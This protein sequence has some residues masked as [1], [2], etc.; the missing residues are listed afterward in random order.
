MNAY[1]GL[2]ALLADAVT[3]RN[4]SQAAARCPAHDD[5]RASLSIGIRTQGDPGA[6][7]TCQA[8]CRVDDVLAVHGLTTAAL[9]DSWWEHRNGGEPIEVYRYADESGT[10]LFEVGRFEGKRFF[11]R[12]PGR[13][14][15]KGGI[16]G[17]RRVLYRLPQVI[18]GVA[19]GRRIWIVEGE[20]DVHAIEGAGEIGTCNP[21]GAGKWRD[22][23]S[24][25]LAGATVTVVADGDEAGRKHARSVADSLAPVSASVTVVESPTHKDARDHLAA[26]GGLDGFVLLAV[27]P[28][29]ENSRYAGRH[30][31]LAALLAMPARPT[32]WRVAEVVAD[33]TLTTISSESGAGKSWLA[34]SFCEGVHYGEPVVGLACKQG[35]ALYVDAEMGS[36]MFVGR[37]RSSGATGREYEYIDAMGLDVSRADDLA[38]FRGQIQEVSAN[39]VVFDSL[40]ALAP[41]KAENDS[42]D[43]APVV[44]NLRKLARDTGAGI[45]LIHHKGDGEKLFRGSTTIRDQSDA[46]FGLQ[47]FEDDPEGPLRHMWCPVK[48]GA[49]RLRYS[50]DA[51][52]VWLEVDPDDGT[53]T[54]AEGPA[55]RTVPEVMSAVTAM[56][57]ALLAA[58]P[59]RTKREAA[60]K[61]GCHPHNKAFHAAWQGLRDTGR[62]VKNEVSEWSD[63]LGTG[64]TH[65]PRQTSGNIPA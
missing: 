56:R 37:L 41:S 7:V 12:R 23:Y 54:M 2:L 33:G 19:A 18:E 44:S 38:W 48:H 63:P 30:V 5:R 34:Q 15:W 22:E 9:Y 27:A 3:H 43:M 35:V 58:L 52:D 47:R 31:D 4:G 1:N 8:G 13:S 6:V 57:D 17:V 14:D 45:I 24:A 55:E 62:L 60:Q 53:V 59:F 32:P 40:R 65:S 20:R 29:E 51:A 26:R 10:V 11:Q 39:L 21:G 64:S 36:T 28:V 42:D 49:K 16:K 46:L 61:V 25:V 50:P